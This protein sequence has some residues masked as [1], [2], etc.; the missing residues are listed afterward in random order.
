MA[1]IIRDWTKWI[2]PRVNENK[3]RV[4]LDRVYF[5]PYRTTDTISIRSWEEVENQTREEYYFDQSYRSEVTNIVQHHSLKYYFMPI[6]ST[7]K[8]QIRGYFSK[9]MPIST[10]FSEINEVKDY[11]Y[12]LSNE[13]EL[14]SEI[15]KH[16]L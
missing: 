16:L 12:K 8:C 13:K 15:S 4:G 7:N 6:V 3:I 9:V 10:V 5:P 1:Y 14:F 11:A 2:V